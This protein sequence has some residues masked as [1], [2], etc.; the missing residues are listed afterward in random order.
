MQTEDISTPDFKD[1]AER[2]GLEQALFLSQ[3]YGGEYIYIPKLESVTREARNKDIRQAFNGRNYRELGQKYNL[4][5]K[6]I[7]WILFGKKWKQASFIG[8]Q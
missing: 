7:R 3:Q 1:I 2:I 8:E 4:S 6:S 5:T